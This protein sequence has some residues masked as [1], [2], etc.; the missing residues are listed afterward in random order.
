MTISI[1][2]AIRFDERTIVFETLLKYVV[3]FACVC[4]LS[5]RR[6]SGAVTM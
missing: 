2:F 1:C 3:N 6:V 4:Q 5:P